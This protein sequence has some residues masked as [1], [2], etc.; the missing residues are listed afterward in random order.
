MAGGASASTTLI[1]FSR[2]R[3][4]TSG[5]TDPAS[6]C[7]EKGSTFTPTAIRDPAWR[8]GF[9][10]A[11]ALIMVRLALSW[12]GFFLMYSHTLPLGARVFAGALVFFAEADFRAGAFLA[13]A[14]LAGAFFAGALIA[15]DFF[16][17]AFFA[18]D[19]LVEA[20]FAVAMCRFSG[21]G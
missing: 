13:G 14:L 20:F 21:S 15:G 1:C 5:T 9:V 4:S 2:L 19:L 3:F 6:S 8:Q 12:S 16:P 17:G 11:S 18:G 7:S 10:L